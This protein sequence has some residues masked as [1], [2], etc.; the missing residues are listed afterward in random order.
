MP[1]LKYSQRLIAVDF[2]SNNFSGPYP[3]QYFA[4]DEYLLLEFVSAN[5]NKLTVVPDICIRQAYCYKTTFMS[6][7]NADDY[8]FLEREITDIIDTS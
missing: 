4:K 6:S 2:S 5:F 1:I 8:M 7:R 3:S